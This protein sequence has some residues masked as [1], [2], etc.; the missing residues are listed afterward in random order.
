MTPTLESPLR[1]ILFGAN[2]MVGAAVLDTC[3]NDPGV[4]A[5]LA[6][7]RKPSGRSHPKLK[8][9]LVPNLSQ[10]AQ[11]QEQLQ[12]YNACFYTL[13]VTSAGRSEAEYR[14]VIV[15]L[16]VNISKVLVAAS[17]GLAICFVSGA[18]SDETG[19]GKVMWAR[20][21]GEA[22]NAVLGLGFGRATIIR[23]GGLVPLKHFQSSTQLY[24][25]LYV[26]LGPWLPLLH[27]LWPKMVTTPQILGTAMIRAARGLAPKVRLEPGDIDTLGR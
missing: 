12:G 27:R 3:L 18:A 9:L 15:S 8:D 16:T 24:R 6:V 25:V 17:P 22:E 1:V 5:V 21:K 4:E 26:L 10:L 23:L 11:V 20:V 7:G 14:A 19:Q 2:G 13:G